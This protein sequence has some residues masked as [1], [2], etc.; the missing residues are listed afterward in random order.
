MNHMQLVL[1][2]S[3][4]RQAALDSLIADQHDRKSSRFHQ[5]LTPKEF[6]ESYGVADSDI[7]AAK[8]WLVSQ[9]FTVNNVYPNKMQIDF[10]GKAGQV[11]RAFHTQENHYKMK[12][13][14]LHVANAGDISVPAALHSVIT[15]VAG[16]NSF[17]PEALNRSKIAKYDAKKGLFNVATSAGKTG[18][19]TGKIGQAISFTN[20][21]RGLVPN[22]LATMYNV[23]PLRDNGVT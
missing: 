22:D 12:D 4:A 6:G 20:G 21:A 5:W 11:N 15:G 3:S 18:H 7:A 16:L 14:S 1:K 23:K 19:G 9:G 13:G 10:S 8:A 2:R 17:H